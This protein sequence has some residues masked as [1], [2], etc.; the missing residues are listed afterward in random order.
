MNEQKFPEVEHQLRA[1]RR[2]AASII[3]EA[4]LRQKLERSRTTGRPMVVKL[5]L[6]PTAPDLHLGHTVVLGKLRDF[7]ELGHA[8]V[9]VIGD[10]TGMIGDPTGRSETR[11][12]LTWEQ[13]RANAET[14]RTQLGK[15]VDMER[16]RVE[17]NSTWLGALKFEDLI[18]LT[19]HLT[20]A[21]M[22]QREDF[23]S[24]YAEGRAISLHEFLYPVAQAYDSVALHADVEL[25]GTDQTFNL[26]VG[27]DLQRA[28]GQEPQV[29]LT[30]PLLEGLDGVQKMSK[31]LGNYVGI[32][33]PPDDIFGKLM[34]VPDTMMWRY[35]ELLTRLDDAEIARLRA[36]HPMDAKKRLASMITAQYHGQAAAVAAQDRFARIFQ[37]RQQPE[38]A[39]VVHVDSAA[40]D[41]E[42]RAGDSSLVRVLVAAGMTPSSSEARRM[43][44]QGAVD[45]DG[46]RVAD[47]NA[48]ITHGD[49]LVR[50]GKRVFK[51]VVL[52]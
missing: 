43:I 27:R 33:E 17:F 52:R 35:F 47:V 7:Q 42:E 48:R 11:K 49:H 16:V 37:Q 36:G 1:L 6:D 12:P 24:R 10:F 32:D 51:R 4:E 44:R 5:G 18:R 15:V 23:A 41:G 21:Q 19:A 8:I 2:G 3:V 46:E 20:V 45:V 13:I 50:V 14:Y 40:L 31:S 34:S 22:L 26:L 25:G 39:E 9:V 30:V 28:T 29:T 38:A